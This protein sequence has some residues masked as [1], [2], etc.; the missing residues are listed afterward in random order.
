MPNG[1]FPIPQFRSE[2]PDATAEAESLSLRIRTRLK[3]DRLDDQLASGADPAGKPELALRAA[4]LQSRAGRS[5]LANAIG[6][7]LGKAHEPNLGRFTAAGQ[8][9]HAQIREYAENL[10]ALAA[11]LRDDNPVDVQAAA[12]TARLVNDRSSPLHRGTGDSL[13]STVLSVRLALDRPAPTHQRLR[14]AA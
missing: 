11:R 12:M 6:E 7:V 5:R 10:R 1:I 9:R 2:P 13:A 4:Q 3:R 14:N 8:Q